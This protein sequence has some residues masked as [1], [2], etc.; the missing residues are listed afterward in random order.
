MVHVPEVLATSRM[1]TGNKTVGQRGKA[2][3]ETI[4]VLKTHYDYV[5]FAW[6]HAYA[7]YLADGRDQFFEELR[8]SIAKYILSLFIGLR[9]NVRHPLRYL[10]DWARVMSMRGLARRWQGFLG[11]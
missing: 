7:A 11:K 3:H 1:H 4:Q 9:V 5:P 8:P 6:I 2:L 10:H